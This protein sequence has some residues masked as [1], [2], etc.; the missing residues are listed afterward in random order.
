MTPSDA[1]LAI[2]GLATGLMAA[3]LGLAGGTI[4]TPIL[5]AAGYEP[6]F[7][8]AAGFAAAVAGGSAG[9]LYLYTRGVLPARSVRLSLYAITGSL[10][11]ALLSLQLP[12][13]VVYALVASSLAVSAVM[14]VHRARPRLPQSLLRP[15]LLAAG[16]IA[17]ATGKGGGSLYLPIYALIENDSRRAASA[18]RL[19]ASLAALAGLT[20]Y[21]PIMA[22]HLAVIALVS[23]STYL[24]GSLGSRLV[25]RARPALHRR[26]AVA[27]YTILA[28]LLALRAASA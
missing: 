23:A 14:L 19:T 4:L 12:P 27:C 24:G 18:A 15:S 28:L 20:V 9:T 11:G 22:K 26:L 6:R 1:L 7:A 2:A 5:L 10:I 21:A 25:A 17:G 3:L 13:R 8:L 16:I